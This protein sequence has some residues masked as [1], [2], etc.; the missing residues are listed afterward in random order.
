MILVNMVGDYGAT[1][2]KDVG[3]TTGGL[4]CFNGTTES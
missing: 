3:E 1:G 2:G 4:T